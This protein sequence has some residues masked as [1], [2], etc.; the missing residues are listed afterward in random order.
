MSLDCIEDEDVR[1]RF[2]NI[3]G[4]LMYSMV[5]IRPDITYAVKLVSRYMTNLGKT[6]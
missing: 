5:S 2:G 4:S 1:T 3:V 6:Q